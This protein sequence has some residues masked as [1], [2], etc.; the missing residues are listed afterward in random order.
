[1]GDD[2]NSQGDNRTADVPH[3]DSPAGRQFNWA[4][5]PVPH[6]ESASGQR[7]GWSALDLPHPSSPVAKQIG[8]GNQ[9]RD[10]LAVWVAELEDAVA[11]ASANLRNSIPDTSLRALYDRLMLRIKS[12]YVP[13]SSLGTTSEDGAVL[14]E[15]LGRPVLWFDPDLQRNLQDTAGFVLAAGRIGQV[16]EFGT[17]KERKELLKNIEALLQRVY[18]TAADGIQQQWAN[19]KRSGKQ[20]EL[21]QKWKTQL[22]REIKKLDTGSVEALSDPASLKQ[23]QVSAEGAK[24]GGAGTGKSKEKEKHWIGVKVVDEIGK[25]VKDVAVQCKLDDGTLLTMDVSASADGSYKTEK[26][27]DAAKGDFSFPGLFNVEWWPEGGSGGKSPSA[28]AAPAVAPGDC[29]LSIADGLGFRNYHSVWDQPQNDALKKDRPNP[30]MLAAG[31]VVHAPDKKDKVVK[32]AVDQTWIFV[33]RRKRPFTLR[34]VLYDKN[35]K[36]LGGKAWE[37]K[38]PLSQTGTTGADGLIEITGLQPSDKI[39]TLVVT[40]APA[41]PA[42]PPKPV[43]PAAAPANPPPYPPPIVPQ[44]FKDKLPPLDP[45][46][47]IVTWNLSIGGLPAVK[48]KEGTLARLHNLAFGC[49]VDSDDAHAVHA[50]KAYQLFYLKAKD[51]SGKIADIQDDA[52]QRH[53]N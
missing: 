42:P 53:D 37:L 52:A 28:M 13:A 45:G 24:A 18:N 25:P 46:P 27:L 21:T 14:V 11:T 19:A 30:N 22:L 41:K 8:W 39:G 10:K 31:D 47:Q 38:T 6:P 29:V 33:V 12:T 5:S 1:M 9:K 16:W 15:K 2:S 17:V 3:P 51:G 20:P 43:P 4:S 44:D 32:K 48:V 36:P 49:D 34:L 40:M 23:A 7:F 50:V 35:D 26:V